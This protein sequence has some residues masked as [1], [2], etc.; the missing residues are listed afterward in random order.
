MQLDE[1]V[2]GTEASR[3]TVS[4]KPV[5]F[6]NLG[7]LLTLHAKFYE[8]IDLKLLV[9][10]LGEY[11]V[12]FF[13][14]HYYRE[15]QLIGTGPGQKKL[16]LI[17]NLG[18]NYRLLFLDPLYR[19]PRPDAFLHYTDKALVVGYSGYCNVLV[20]DDMKSFAEKKSDLNLAQNCGFQFSPLKYWMEGTVITAIENRADFVPAEYFPWKLRKYYK[21]DPNIEP[22]RI[23]KP[24]ILWIAG[25]PSSGKSVL[26]QFVSKMWNYELIT[27]SD[28]FPTMD[29]GRSYVV[30]INPRS[31]SDYGAV[32]RI[33]VVE[34]QNST[35]EAQM[36]ISSH[37][38]LAM[39]RFRIETM[40]APLK[41]DL[42][43]VEEYYADVC[44]FPV[45]IKLEYFD[46][47]PYQYFAPK[48][49]ASLLKYIEKFLI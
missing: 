20:E 42:R 2:Y 34:E 32:S 31:R 3:G 22:Y 35:V 46:F 4:D 40:A 47:I 19:S 41:Y 33:F 28:L 25:P 48:K 17:D 10:R 43:E 44:R 18:I 36:L 14:D 12:I 5:L 49:F 39:K 26:A 45:G 24:E 7:I 15:S 23:S 13:D 6:I 16:A 8:K 11:E 37:M 9:R 21:Y 1:N 30:D 29:P 38:L 27:D